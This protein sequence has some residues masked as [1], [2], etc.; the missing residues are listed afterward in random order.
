MSLADELAVE[1]ERT[2]IACVVCSWV[3]EQDKAVREHFAQWIE[4]GG[5][6]SILW[7][8]CSRR[9]LVCAESTMRKHVQSCMR[10]DGNYA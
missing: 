1:F 4:G 8:V 5:R 9:G 7:R 10:G 2:V 6:A 3:K